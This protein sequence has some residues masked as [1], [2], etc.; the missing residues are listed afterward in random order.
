MSEYYYNFDEERQLEQWKI[1]ASQDDRVLGICQFECD[2]EGDFLL[3][4]DTKRYYALTDADVIE[5]C[6][7]NVVGIVD[8]Y[9]GKHKQRHGIRRH[10]VKGTN[11]ITA[12]LIPGNG[13]IADFRMQL[14]PAPVKV[15]LAPDYH[16]SI[17]F[18][19]SP[20]LQENDE[21]A[22]SG[23]RA[24]AGHE[25]NPG[26]FGFQKQAG[27][28]DCGMMQ[29]GLISKMFLCG[30][31]RY[32]K[33]WVWGYSLIQE[34]NW[35][36]DSD[37]YQVLSHMALRWKRG[38]TTFHASMASACIVTEFDGEYMK[39]SGLNFAGNYQYVLTAGEVASTSCFSG[40]L[41]E[42]WLLLFGCTEYPDVPLLLIPDRHP[43]R[44]EFLRD[45]DNRLTEVR[46][47][48]C[49]RL[50]TAT[51]FGFEP[52]EPQTPEDEKFLADATAR[53]RFW[54]RASLSLPVNC[55]EY[56]YNDHQKKLVRI[57]QKFEYCNFADEWGTFPLYLAPLP[58]MLTIGNEHQIP[59]GAVDFRFPTKYGPLYGFRGR[60]SEYSVAMMLTYRK[61]PLRGK[62]SSAEK[63]LKDGLDDYFE[64]M[65]RFPDTEQ[66]YAYPGAILESYAYT[67]SMI[68]FMP[69]DKR[70][71]LA[72][73][74]DKRLNYACNPNRQYT[75]LL[76]DH[77][78]L[79][80]E[81]PERDAVEQ[82]Y[83][84]NTIRR[85]KMF[86]L[87]ERQEPFTG[88]RYYLC[89]FN[90][91][92][93]FVGALKNGTREE[94]LRYPYP[95]VEND[96]GIGITFYMMYSA[97]LA[98]GDYSAIRK[99]WKHIQKIF[100]FFELYY[101]WACMGG[102]YAEKARCWIEGANFGAFTSYINMAKTVGDMEAYEQGTYIAA[103]MLNL[104]RARFSLGEYFAR[105]YHVK[106]WYGARYFYEEHS[107]DASFQQ[108]PKNNAEE[109]NA[110]ERVC[111]I[112]ISLLTTDAIYP[113]LFDS[114]RE[115][116]P[117]THRMI[118]NRYRKLLGSD[119]MQHLNDCSYLL[120]NDALDPEIPEVV[121]RKNLADTVRLGRILTQWHDVN[122]FENNMP[123]HYLESQILA[124]LEMRSHGMW[125]E[126]WQGLRICDATWEQDKQKACLEIEI[127]EGK[128]L[129]RCGLNHL[130]V[131]AFFNEKSIYWT[132]PENKI[133]E[134][135]PE[136]N[137]MLVIRF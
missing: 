60:N 46:L 132:S 14:V 47:Y 61:F 42:N 20:E 83:K 25:R 82:Y 67:A 3:L 94:V 66:S 89:Y 117:M 126:H 12:L 100:R 9:I 52:L 116:A 37:E 131:E 39:V 76:S 23:M 124:W 88:K 92:M 79:W 104:C 119:F 63:K 115:T 54:G 127:T 6:G 123:E 122:R 86:N 40:Q 101:D 34:N 65:S 8:F 75:L 71:F 78:K 108:V 111:R 43:V 95:F 109:F 13:G 5:V 22:V 103:K 74:L 57:I 31:P 30:D 136:E 90:V 1:I 70:D 55:Q 21:I 35:S 10:L 77:H 107:T 87:Y 15:R 68:N 62:D 112:G 128:T 69:R 7:I 2:T 33:P 98:S 41:P 130:P 58:P 73:E 27:F 133:I 4:W 26:R 64:F 102:G 118:M 137:G 105:Y 38:R 36:A 135:H 110:Q 53:C 80:K 59:E 97:A 18:A 11:M 72:K 28:L 32:R 24:G 19:E 93:L 29:Y 84:G 99:N 106:P 91:G 17:R 114:F 16:R 125:L 134:F 129:L 48:G 45:C 44:I 56:F 120:I 121:T 50:T 49:K 51:P 85:M 81:K 96:W 113:E